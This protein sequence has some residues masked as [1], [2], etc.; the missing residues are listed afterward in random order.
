[1]II[2]YIIIYFG[3][4]LDMDLANILI[5]IQAVVITVIK[6]IIR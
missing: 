4:I 2:Q 5:A 3:W 6:K 1:M